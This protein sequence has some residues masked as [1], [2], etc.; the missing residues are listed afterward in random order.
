MYNHNEWEEDGQQEDSSLQEIYKRKK[1][2]IQIAAV[3]GAAALLILLLVQCG[4]SKDVPAPDVDDAPP[5]NVVMEDDSLAIQEEI[6]QE[7]VDNMFQVIMNTRVYLDNGTSKANLLIENPKSN[8]RPLF[9]DIYLKENDEL[10]YRSNTISA[11]GKVEN[12]TLTKVL[13]KGTYPCIAYF[14]ALDFDTQEEIN[15]VG[16]NLEIEVNA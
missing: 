1:R 10:L 2:K 7:V 6:N 4:K 11:G 5:T 14:H 8:H 3:A 13:S 15:R 12:A 9:V 16:V